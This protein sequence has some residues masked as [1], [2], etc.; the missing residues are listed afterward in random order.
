MFLFPLL[1]R[2]RSHRNN[3]NPSFAFGT[4]RTIERGGGGKRR[5]E[6]ER[7]KCQPLGRTFSAKPVPGNYR[8]RQFKAT[9]AA[10]AG[11]QKASKVVPEEEKQ[12]TH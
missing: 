8:V 11:K 2:E 7:K 6:I 4:K 5:G 3:Q 9:T 12:V 10:T 1:S